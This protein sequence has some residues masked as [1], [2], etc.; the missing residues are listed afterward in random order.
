MKLIIK[1]DILDD[2]SLYLYGKVVLYNL[3]FF[4]KDTNGLFKNI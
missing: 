4:E 1:G 2:I 3:L